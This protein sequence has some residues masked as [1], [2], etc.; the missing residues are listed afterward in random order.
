MLN[1]CP[2]SLKIFPRFHLVKVSTHPNT[3]SLLI[4]K[5]IIISVSIQCFSH[6]LCVT[7]M[8]L[9]MPKKFLWCFSF[10][11]YISFDQS[12]LTSHLICHLYLFKCSPL[13]V[14]DRKYRWL[15]CCWCWPITPHSTQ[16]LS[17][18]WI[19][20]SFL[21]VTTLLLIRDVCHSNHLCAP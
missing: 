14:D 6:R 1:I 5:A 13:G 21:Y 10:F 17:S 18:S 9:Y 4:S 8:C 11:L 2:F 3:F 12:W 16:S 19:A 15:L 20:V 7:Y